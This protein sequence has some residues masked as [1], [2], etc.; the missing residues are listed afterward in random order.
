MMLKLDGRFLF[1]L[2]LAARRFR[3]RGGRTALVALGVAAAAGGLAAVLGGSLVAEDRNLERALARIPEGRR[4]LQVAHF[5]VPPQGSGYAALDRRVRRALA[6][7]SR[8]TPIRALQYRETRVGGRT[9]IL[10]GLDGVGRWVQVRSGRLPRS[11]SPQRC[12][13]IQLGGTGAVRGQPG[14]RLVRVGR[15][16]LRSALPFGRLDPGAQSAISGPQN[17]FAPDTPPPFVLTE[18]TASVSGLPALESRY[19][20]YLWTVPLERGSMHAWDVDEYERTVARIRSELESASLLF[21]V[22]APVEELEAAAASGDTAASRLLLI[23][24]EG[25]ALLLVFA[26][27]AGAGARQET[28]A[29][30]QRLTWYGARRW[31]LVVFT[32]AQTVLVVLAAGVVGW[33]AG[34]GATLALAQ[35]AGT[36]AGA[37]AQHSVLAG[38]GLAAFGLLVAAATALLLLSLRAGSLRIGTTRLSALDLVAAGA[39]AAVALGLARGEVSTHSL[40]EERG[41]AVFVL[42]LPALTAFVIAWAWARL[43]PPALLALERAARSAPAAV[44]LGF[45]SLL[46][47]PGRATIAVAFLVVSFGIALFAALYRSTLER[48]QA[49]QAAYAFPAD[50]LI[51]EDLDISKLVLPLE[52]A[53]LSRYQDL[54]RDLEVVAV[55]RQRGSVSRLAR[56]GSLTLLGVPV[57]SFPRLRGWRSD[58]SSL[59]LAEIARRLEEGGGAE[60]RGAP[61]PAAARELL[62]PVS[63]RGDD[64]ALGA[65]ILTRRGDFAGVDLGQVRGGRAH[66][67]RAR[68]PEEA[69]GGR[70][71][72]LTLGLAPADQE[73]GGPAQGVLTLEPLRARLPGGRA[74]LVSDYRGWRGVTGVGVLERAGGVRLRYFVTNQAVSRFRPRQPGEGR[75]LPVAVTPALAEAAGPGGELPVRL[76][77]AQLVG[78]VVA[79]LDRFPTVYGDVVLADERRLFTW[80]NTESPGAA[81]P[82]EIWLAAPS[83]GEA[84][85]LA[86]ELGR[87]PFDVLDVQSRA[88]LEEELRG[89]P[90]S[91]GALAI[92]AVAAAVALALALAGLLLSVLADLR[93]ER[94]ELFD[95]ESEGFTTVE[96]RRHVR[97][98]AATVAFFGAAG[99]VVL[100]AV[101]AATVVDLVA[102]TAEARVPEP[103][104]LLEV[105]W[106]ALAL[107]LLA[108]AALA[109]A[110]VGAA[111]RWAFRS[112][113]PGRAELAE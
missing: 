73:S 112:P 94:G 79:T 55:V 57:D 78:R 40:T 95:L 113:T 84:R 102:V 97:L 58:F 34:T 27:L 9:V 76:P 18:G 71:V 56:P 61:I 88:A 68:L 103:P 66:V 72:A 93:D 89:D 85:R 111:T 86:G 98:R 36:P 81:F 42:L 101:L 48:G 19:R 59:S 108:F 10:A 105:D 50:F 106:P 65:S 107:G 29:A 26:L 7:L 41:T 44:R 28:E 75:P 4:G 80:L 37:V 62:L 31:Q 2:A 25:A 60:L 21:D 5:G 12:E 100:G 74:A 87:P 77:G 104:L 3:R 22:T 63:V 11:C 96:L 64:F 16:T 13:V 67:L 14:V 33:V 30:W 54:G 1:P 52:A 82:N 70:L 43:L 99:G 49:D 23:G 69:R 8:A 32:A 39:L 15:G 92:L 109:A 90:L 6:P 53:P 83:P 47:R 24:G 17:Y 35:V 51:R 20:A 91:R 110:L 46:R 38:A 45:L